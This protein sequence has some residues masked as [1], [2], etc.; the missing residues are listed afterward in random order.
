[1]AIYH[2]EAQIFSR[3]AGRSAV[4]CAA[5]RSGEALHDEREG[6][7]FSFPDSDRVAHCEILAPSD[8]PAWARSRADLWNQVEAREKRPDSQLAREFEVAL[9]RD[10]SLTQQLE[11]LRGWVAAEITP[12]G[13][14]ADLAIHVDE[15]NNNPHAHIMTTMR[16]VSAE[17]WGRLK[18]RAWEDR[19]ALD[20]WRKSWADHTNAALEKAAIK[21]RVDHRSN[22][23]RGIASVLEPTKKEGPGARG[24]ARRG[25]KSDRVANNAAI[26]AR[27]ERRIREMVDAIVAFAKAITQRGR[28]PAQSQQQLQA[29]ARPSRLPSRGPMP[30]ASTPS[31]QPQAAAG[32]PRPSSQGPVPKVTAPS[33]QPQPAPSPPRAPQV[34]QAPQVPPPSAPPTSPGLTDE[35]L[36]EYWLQQGGLGR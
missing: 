11:L 31:Q 14:I 4:A 13:A 19:S 5:Y 1:M 25:Q 6:S 20:R 8:A 9:P 33:Q 36:Q 30:K 15:D 3:S 10:L 12:A 26:K 34:T 22:E 29:V 24:R 2:F 35:Q 32:P 23:E 7:T 18:I 21:A 16:A 17:G 27:N 28:V